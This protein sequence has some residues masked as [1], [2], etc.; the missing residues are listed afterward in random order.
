MA[1]YYLLNAASLPPFL[2]LLPPE[3]QAGAAVPPMITA[4]AV[5]DGTA[6]AAAL[7]RREDGGARLEY[8]SVAP[9]YRRRGVAL[10][11]LNYLRT[12]LPLLDCDTLWVDLAPELGEDAPMARLLSGLGLTK[13]KGPA[14]A[15]CPVAAL[16]NSSLLA[17]LLERDTPGV[18]P[19]GDV[20][21]PVLRACRAD[22]LQRG[23]TA[24]PLDWDAFDPDLSFCGLNGKQELTCCVCTRP[25][26]DD[27]SVEW[28]YA[29]PAGAKQLILA[30]AAL[31]RTARE[32]LPPNAAFS[33]V[34]T[35]DRAAHLLARLAG[36]AATYRHAT[37][38]E[39]DLLQGLERE[40]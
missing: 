6:V 32:K 34:L 3:L 4:G 12:V 2:S 30:V 40:E 15:S 33:A 5:E 1:D 24:A 13:E 39:W 14:I 17:P 7:L 31:L 36:D 35:D 22:L 23:I 20:P 38:W 9:E 10:G 21:A 26:P 29:T 37:H 19:L 8:L 16:W 27:V 28:I 25:Q 11:L 18:V